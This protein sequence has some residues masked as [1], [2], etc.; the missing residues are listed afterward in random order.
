MPRPRRRAASAPRAALA[1]LALVASAASS[2]A[3]ETPP[4]PPPEAPAPPAAEEPAERKPSKRVETLDELLVTATLRDEPLFDLPASA[5]R[6]DAEE[7]RTVR[8]R[9]TLPDALLDTP[10][11]MVQKTAYG[12][13]SPFIR[14]FTGYQTVLLV[15]GIRLNNS[16]FRS[17][18]NQYFSTIDSYS[19]ESLEVVRGA[20]SV[21]HGSDAVGGALNAIA[22]PSGLDGEEG[23]GGRVIGRFATAENSWTERAEIEGRRGDVGISLGG[24]LRDFDDLRAGGDSG[25]LPETAYREHAADFRLDLQDG[26][27]ARWTLGYQRMRQHEVPRTEQTIH[28][29]PFHG[30]VAGTELRRDLDQD[31]DLAWGR[32]DSRDPGIRFAD[33]LEATVSWHRQR[34]KQ[35]RT[36]TGGRTDNQ[37]VDVKTLGAQLLGERETSIGRWTVGADWWHDEVDSYRSDRVNGVLGPPQIQGPVG[38]DASYDLAGVFVQDAIPAGAATITAGARFTWASAEAD[39]VDD[40]TVPGTNPATP[41]NVIS[42][43]DDWTSVVG[44]LR[45][46]VPAS[47]TVNLF[48]GVSQA[49]RAPN[50]SDL[51][52]LDDTSGV[53]TPSPG[54][55]PEEY[56]TA[57]VGVRVRRETWDLQAAVWRTWIDGQIVPSPTGALIGGTPE[58]RKDNVGDGWAHGVEI[59]AAWRPA[60]SWTL[61]G[62]FTWM[63]GEVDQLLP[64]GVE[65]REPLSRMMPTTVV[66]TGT[67]APP[68]ARWRAWA[69]VRA[70]DEQD[71]LSL[72]DA[73]DARRI[74]PGGTPGYA[75]A[76]VGFGYDIGEHVRASLVLENLFDKDYRIHGSG[77]NEPGRNLVAAVEFAF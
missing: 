57:D 1:A 54:L 10:S 72:K 68:E 62:G 55:D 52:R 29:V 74:P 65:V 71:E 15:D 40:P 63:E 67:L 7:I 16:T 58:V 37:G 70:A 48:G 18:P 43:D 3:Q 44:S 8:A 2:R 25:R 35:E 64:S 14:G 49:F 31:R 76:S 33:R 69:S 51:T 9:R 38:D 47:E 45:A 21:L 61:A 77:V 34:E 6:I 27:A 73:T 13:A 66:L 53:E 11:V 30:T 24:T 42:I 5:T 75:V 4:A 26:P 59:E 41:G 12:Q 46:V 28:S 50:L 39:R 22:R 19:V 36:R 23:W 20:A 32:W 56:L 60:P 17:G